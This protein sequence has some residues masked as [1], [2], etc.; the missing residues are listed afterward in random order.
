MTQTKTRRRRRRPRPGI[1]RRRPTETV[2]GIGGFTAVYAF[3]TQAGVSHP[4]AA[5][6]A[7]VAGLVPAIVTAI[8]DRLGP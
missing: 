8:K 2:A 5:V 6:L 7:V 1:L 3:L 4:V